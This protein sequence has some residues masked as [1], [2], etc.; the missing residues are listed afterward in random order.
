[1]ERAVEH[2]PVQKYL[3][4][5]HV[6]ARYGGISARTVARR[7][8]RGEL[9]APDFYQGRFPYWN[10]E[11]L[12]KWDAARREEQ[13]RRAADKTNDAQAS[14]RNHQKAQARFAADVGLGPAQGLK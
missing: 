2:H 10:E 8:A 4:V 14:Q 11:T 6:A 5:A 3:R 12:T 7:V 9:P 1:M 13:A